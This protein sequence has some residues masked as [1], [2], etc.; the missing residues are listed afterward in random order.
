VGMK[1]YYYDVENKFSIGN[2]QMCDS[3]TELLGISD[4]VTLHVPGTDITK[5]TIGKD[6]ISAMK[7]RFLFDKCISWQCCCD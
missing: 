2:A 7:K 5:E 1:V 6:E 3:L 4:I